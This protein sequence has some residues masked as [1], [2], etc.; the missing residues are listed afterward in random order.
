MIANETA[1]VD[2]I[3]AVKKI[4]IIITTIVDFNLAPDNKFSDA[5]KRQRVSDAV[6][7]VN[8]GL[9]A[10]AKDRGI[11]VM[12]M[13]DYADMSAASKTECS[14]SAMCRLIPL[15]PETTRI[16]ACWAITFTPER[17]GQTFRIANSYLKL[18]NEAM[19]T[20]TRPSPMRKS[21]PPPGYHHNS[22]GCQCRLSL[23][24]NGCCSGGLSRMTWMRYLRCTA[25]RK[26]DNISPEVY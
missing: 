12:D 1:A 5:T 13:T 7:R 23:R 18:I 21:S 4:P 26:F 25:I 8:A 10:M 22:K 2:T 14:W 16:T 19:G 6:E 20:N 15:L 24:Q 3:L 17:I 11:Y 9:K